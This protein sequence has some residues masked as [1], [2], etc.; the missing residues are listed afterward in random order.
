MG[1]TTSTSQ[2]P[3]VKFNAAGYYTV[4]LTA[5]N[6]GGSDGETKT[7][8]ILASV[9]P[10]VANFSASTTTPIVG[11]T[12]TFTDL[13]TNA[14]TSWA[15]S[16]SP[17]TITY[18][19]G[20][21]STSQHPQVLF[22]AAGYYT[23]TLTA[24][25]SGG[26]DGETK[27]NYINALDNPPVATLKL[28][29][30]TNPAPGTVLV[31]VTLEAINNPAAGN[32]LVNSW[33]WFIAYDA[34]V[35]YNG[36]PMGPVNLTNYHPLF[37]YINYMTNIL[38][39]YPSP[40]WN[41][42]AMVYTSDVSAAASVGMKF[43]DIVF[44]YN[45]GSTVCPNLFW[46][47]TEITGSS[48]YDDGGNEF[49]MTLINGCVWSEPPV[50]DFMANSTNPF[51]GQT[52]DFIDLSTNYPTSWLWSFNP[53][54]VT[55]VNGTSSTSQNPQV[56]FNNT[57]LYTATLIASN[58][59]GA[60]TETKLNYLT[61]KSPFIY[62]DLT[63][64][65]QGT[66]NGTAMTPYLNG[67]LPFTQPYNT[68]PWNYTGTENV[69]SIPNANV[70]D[71]VLIELRDATNVAS[72]TSA[73]M[74]DQKAAFLL[75]NGKVVG[76]DGASTL[77][78]SN[79]LTQQLYVV[80]WHRNHL[81]VMTSTSVTESGGIYTYNFSTG[82]GQAYGGTS[83]HKQIGPGVWGMIGGDG[84]KD[85]QITASDESLIWESQAGTKGY[86]ESDYNLNT[87]TDNKD[88]NDIWAPNQ[89]AGSQVLD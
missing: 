25:N 72:A 26:S 71:W 2:N 28:G 84:D 24:T 32:N 79:S 73:T 54:S 51:V 23:V 31:P 76:L 61:V 44:N 87:Q 82:A 20:T 81:G 63:V 10:P 50:T 64:F 49:I 35:L 3:Q 34:S 18:V 85:G 41:T 12:L 88:K 1:G 6:A 46:T 59:L 53:P 58:A 15:W 19:G 60:D 29:T 80:V 8:Y 89:G 47:S 77:Q 78:F 42:L 57:G 67:I 14:P 36:E 48:L 7:N 70:V 74:I 68:T 40:G 43:F 62:L 83:A 69:A 11:Q 21:S 45:P 52:V 75:S 27:T 37:P 30:L 22:V 5:T 17:S 9:P 55:Y 38:E 66:F 13:S 86:L 65:L 56:Q 16:F 33:N 4:T 39:D